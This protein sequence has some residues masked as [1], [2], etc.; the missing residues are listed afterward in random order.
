[1]TKTAGEQKRKE[2]GDFQT[3]PS[4][5]KACLARTVPLLRWRPA[6]VLEPTCGKGAFVSAAA[7]VFDTARIVGVDI[8]P[9]YAS[10][11]ALSAAK[12]APKAAVEVLSR[13]FFEHDW[14]TE[15]QRNPEHVFVVG[16]PPW[17]TSS[18]LGRFGSSNLPA[19][20]NFAGLKGIDAITGKANFDISEWMLHRYVEW[21]V[22]HNGAFAVLCKLSVARKIAKFI[23][24]QY[25]GRSRQAIF[26]IDAKAAFGASVEACLYFGAFDTSDAPNTCEVYSDL[27]S[28]LPARQFGLLDQCSVFDLGVAVELENLWAAS[29]IRWR[30]GV[31]HDCSDILELR[32]R[33]TALVNGLGEE[34]CVEA[35]AIYPLFKS[36]DV[37][38]NS[39]RDKFLLLPQTRLGGDPQGLSICAPRAWSY[40]LSHRDRFDRRASRIYKGRPAF[41]IFGIGEYTLSPWKIA[42]SGLYKSLAFRLIGPTE[43]RPPVFD[44]TVNFLSFDSEDQAR[45]AFELLT[46]PTA[47]RFY[48]AHIFWDE[49]RPITVDILSRLNLERLASYLLRQGPEPAAVEHLHSAA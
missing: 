19:K 25:P 10:E 2:M 40:L 13:D 44:D 31:K 16:N 36:S 15:F 5:A 27:D 46:S 21:C 47:Q 41:S 26:G 9:D 23:W 38:A 34:V 7:E 45:R 14:S 22:S 32:R 1:V 28:E 48:S 20:S 42:I 49:K 24:K 43:G 18:L 11:A 29:T 30:C 3:P 6:L 39:F 17:V 4:L 8:N 37:F 33:G 35:D 12:V